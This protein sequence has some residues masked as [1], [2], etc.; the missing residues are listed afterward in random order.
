MKLV[1]K[2]NLSYSRS[3]CISLLNFLI[4]FCLHLYFCSKQKY[5]ILIVEILCHFYAS[6][7]VC[8]VLLMFLLDCHF[9]VVFALCFTHRGMALLACTHV[10]TLENQHRADHADLILVQVSGMLKMASNK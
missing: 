4:Y 10:K 3:I 6:S 1:S 7:A 5:V 8:H 9:R 2:T